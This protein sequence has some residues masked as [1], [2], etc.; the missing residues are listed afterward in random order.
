MVSS[1]PSLW[2]KIFYDQLSYGPIGSQHYN[3]MLN[4]A[5]QDIPDPH[6]VKY[7]FRGGEGKA[8]QDLL[9]KCRYG[10]TWIVLKESILEWEAILVAEWLNADQDENMATTE[11]ALM[12]PIQLHLR[13]VRVSGCY[14]AG[15]TPSP[16]PAPCLLR[17][18]LDPCPTGR[19]EAASRR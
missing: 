13:H 10:H 7:D 18:C 6:G 4:I 16:P 14:R 2:P 9:T 15:P 5:D 1:R 3:T 11:T 8:V 19:G 17:P 12:Q